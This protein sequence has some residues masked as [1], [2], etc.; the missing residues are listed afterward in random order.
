MVA[1]VKNEALANEALAIMELLW[2]DALRRFF[3]DNAAAGYSRQETA[4]CCAEIL[5][6][7]LIAIVRNSLLTNRGITAVKAEF[8]Q[9]GYVISEKIKT[10]VDEIS[11]QLIK[12]ITERLQQQ[13]LN[14]N[15][16]G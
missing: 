10:E 11:Q 16:K 4:A 1:T 9:A 12:L 13:T 5:S 7:I 15:G 14:Q 2:Y 3:F 8:Q 6:G